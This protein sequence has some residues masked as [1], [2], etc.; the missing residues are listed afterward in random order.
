M[1]PSEQ[2]DILLSR[3]RFFVTKHIPRGEAYI[4]KYPP[5]KPTNESVYLDA[6][7]KEMEHIWRR[8]GACL[9]SMFMNEDDARSLW[10]DDV[11]DEKL[12]SGQWRLIDVDGSE[13]TCAES[14]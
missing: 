14:T 3:Y 6:V 12:A 10:G 4:V 2:I 9:E 7:M 11:V 5:P 8:T 13:D 1:T